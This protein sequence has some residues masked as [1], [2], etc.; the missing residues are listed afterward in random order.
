MQNEGTP[1]KQI[2]EKTLSELYQSSLKKENKVQKMCL[3]CL[4]YSADCDNTR[5][6][7][8]KH[9][10]CRDCTYEWILDK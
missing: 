5:C 2:K 1:K 9:V 8:P 6:S 4:F 3:L 10:T 7:N